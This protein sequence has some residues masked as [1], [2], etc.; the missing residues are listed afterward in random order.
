MRTFPGLT[1]SAALLFVLSISSR[2]Q[3]PKFADYPVDQVFSGTPAAPKLITPLERRYRSRIRYGVKKGWG[4]FRD[5][6]ESDQPGPNFAGDFIV[7]QW[8]CGAPCLMMAM[9]DAR[10]GEV[11]YPPMSI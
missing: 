10:S 1:L 11:F 5:G 7:I 6:K 4:V 9:V 2:A 8:G 3:S